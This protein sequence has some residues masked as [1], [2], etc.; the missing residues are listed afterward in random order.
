M[1]LS[2]AGWRAGLAGEQDG[3]QKKKKGSFAPPWLAFFWSGAACLLAYLCPLPRDEWMSGRGPDLVDNP[4][5]Q[6]R[7]GSPA[8]T[9]GPCFLTLCLSWVSTARKSVSEPCKA[10]RVRK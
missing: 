6:L 4:A 5:R 9:D 7:T 1:L 3:G 8:S 10:P 2:R